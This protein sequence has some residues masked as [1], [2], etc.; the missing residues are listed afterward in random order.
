MF[1]RRQTRRLL[2]GPIVGHTTEGSTRIW[3]QGCDA[4]E[5]YAL[6]VR[7]EGAFP[8][9]P[10]GPGPDE[11]STGIADAVGLR[12]DW[13]Y[14]FEILH[15]GRRVP[16][17]SG[18]FRTFPVPGSPAPIDFVV[19]SCTGQNA[20]DLGAWPLLER[21]VRETQPR[22]LLLIG[23]QVYMDDND[24]PQSPDVWKTHRHSSAE[25]RRRAMVEKYNRNWSRAPLR[26]VFANLP[27]YMIWD[28]HE[29]RDGFGS[30]ACDS[31]TLL[32]K[33]GFERG[34]ALHETCRSFFA[35]AHCVYHHF[36]MAHN[37]DPILPAGEPGQPSALPVRV[38]CGRTLVLMV[39]GR[40]GRDPW[41]KEDPILGAPQWAYLQSEIDNLGADIDALIIAT[42][43]PIVA[44]SPKGQTQNLI[45]YRVDDVALFRRG[46][47][48][49]IDELMASKGQGAGDLIGATVGA[50]LRSHTGLKV[51]VGSLRLGDIDDARDQWAHHWSH[52]EQVR[53]LELAA[54]ART[55]NRPAG[56]PREVTF[57]GGDLHAGGMFEVT[58]AR[59]NCKI[60]S[61]IASGLSKRTNS[62]FVLGALV[63]RDFEVTDGIHA[64]MKTFVND[65]NFGSV[66]VIPTGGTPRVIGKVVHSGTPSA[67]GL[68][69][70]DLAIGPIKLT[71]VG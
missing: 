35:D 43:V 22:F 19:A 29:I 21:F 2:L 70:I 44:G 34:R 54:A 61:L 27:T 20:K 8:F 41:R 18:S 33:P 13:L 71:T 58:F 65:Y 51:N 60:E 67:W 23:D 62:S 59:P 56:Q 5:A 66:Q 39:D 69:R 14:Q 17:A 36:Q 47:E 57:V 53:L 3:I 30:L 1:S 63:D 46:D 68:D 48:A 25:V 64:K 31:E 26:W 38:S 50:Y 45:G 40:G 9:Q 7:G 10:T 4:P 11:F 16:S 6:R 55:V 42:Q 37:P 12:P 15:R 49:G 32:T 24:G 28:D 52:P